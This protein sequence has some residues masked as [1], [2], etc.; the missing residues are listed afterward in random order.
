MNI[1]FI[2]NGFDLRHGMKTGF[3][4]FINH[5]KTENN[6]NVII[7]YFDKVNC[8]NGWLDFEIELQQFLVYTEKF[9]NTLS[10]RT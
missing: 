7:K 4:D 8:S 9:I 1:T 5:Y 3:Y 6:K 10:S 2:G